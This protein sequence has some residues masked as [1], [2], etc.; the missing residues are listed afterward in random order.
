MKIHRQQKN[1]SRN[2][3]RKRT[4]HPPNVSS[5]ISDLRRLAME[6]DVAGNRYEA[7]SVCRQICNTS[8]T[9]SDD[10]INIAA[11]Q[12]FLGNLSAAA[13]V[14]EKAMTDYRQN[15]EIYLKYGAFLSE[16]GKPAEALSVYDKGISIGKNHC[17]IFFEKAAIYYRAKEFEKAKSALSASLI[18]HDICVDY[19]IRIGNSFFEFGDYQKARDAYEKAIDLD[20]N[21]AIA[22]ANR[23]ASLLELGKFEEALSSMNQAIKLNNNSAQ[24]FYNRA[25]IL[26]K[27]GNLNS[28]ICD[29]NKAIDLDPSNKYA[30]YSLSSALFKN[31]DVKNAI[32]A[33]DAALSKDSKYGDAYSNKGV[34]LV[35]LLNFVE[36]QDVLTEGVRADP[37]CFEVYNSLGHILMLCGHLLESEQTYRRAL[38]LD[39]KNKIVVSNLLFLLNYMRSSSGDTLKKEAIQLSR[40]FVNASKV[41]VFDE[42]SRIKKTNL[43]IG[44]VSGDLYGHPVGCFLQSVIEKIDAT[45]ISTCMFYNFNKTDE[46]TEKLRRHSSCWE[47][48]YFTTDEEVAIQ[49][50]S[51]N[52]DIL[53]DLSGHTGRNR[54]SVFV[55]RP[56]PVQL[57][58]LGYCGTTGLAQ[59]DYI[60]GD[61]YVT[62]ESEERHFVEKVWRLPETYWCFTP[63][64]SD[65]EVEDLPAKHNGYITFGCFNNIVKL[66][67]DVIR[68]W[69]MIVKACP[70]SKL[71]LKSRQFSDEQL[72]MRFREKFA[73]FGIEGNR[74]I[75]EGQSKRNEYLTTYNRVD[76]ALDPFP[77]PGGTTSIEGL[78]MGVPFIT[79]KGDRFYSHNGETI[80]HNIG[81]PDWI[82]ADED[83]Y[84]RKAIEFS[85]DL[86]ALA[87][88][89]K[90]LRAQILASP[91]F[92]AERFARNFEK[93]MFDIWERHCSA[94]AQ[95]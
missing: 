27:T 41:I 91:L 42:S 53:F 20:N 89:R 63:P 31:G 23:G 4:N 94:E 70:N 39:D 80:L 86:D 69:A 35:E 17:Y 52:I 38:L 75:I 30:H 77:F 12:K 15:P 56:A 95:N 72:E 87:K 2:K 79:K 71:F 60:L 58:W 43:R 55:Y 93:A 68:L 6:L 46:I 19:A 24:N 10:Y 13:A 14:F 11:A 34:F 5:G 21:S 61:P 57:S 48:I 50:R 49:I 3:K 40:R 33:A 44:F 88:L 73:Q 82:A 25:L 1:K 54:L 8:P 51:Q 45:K 66:N 90:G 85:K 74:M 47:N 92:D 84:L 65:S 16:I 32:S 62:P 78:W 29:F 76:I 18:S 59:I 64:E 9:T 83:D 36:A 22:H 26:S 67:E 28:A 81:L 37:A 7:E